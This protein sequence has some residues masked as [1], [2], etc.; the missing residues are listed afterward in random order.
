MSANLKYE[1]F[2][3]SLFAPLRGLKLSREEQLVAS[4]ILDATAK[5]PI[6]L[7]RLRRSLESAG[8]VISER[9]LKDIVRTLRKRHELPILSR[10][11]Q[12]G[13]FWWCESEQQMRD[14]YKHASRQP[15]DELHTL[16]RIVK[17]NYPRLVGQ[18]SLT[19]VSN[20]E[21]T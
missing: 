13:G 17:A 6:G 16:S 11:N 5:K 14:Y 10:R 18:L 3:E 15:L 2:E 7:K 4:M 12:G 20:T 21:G 19:D 1:I 9:V 8:V